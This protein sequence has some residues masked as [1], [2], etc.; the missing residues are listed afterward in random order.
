[1]F[2][3]VTSSHTAPRRRL[4]LLMTCWS[5]PGVCPLSPALLPAQ[6]PPRPLMVLH[7]PRPPPSRTTTT[8]PSS[9][10]PPPAL[11]SHTTCPSP[12]PSR[13]MRCALW[14]RHQH[15]PSLSSTSQL[16]TTTAASFPLLME[17]ARKAGM[18]WRNPSTLALTV[19]NIMQQVATW[20]DTGKLIAVS[21]PPT[22][23]NV[24]FVTRCMWVCL[25]SACTFSL[26]TS[27]TNVNS[28]ERHS[29]DLGCYKDIWD[30][31]RETNHTP[32]MSARS[33]LQT[34]LTWEHTC[35]H[36]QQQRTSTVLDATNPLH[37]SPIWTNI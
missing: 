32:V 22:P 3:T 2:P 31:I 18:S 25:L 15:N 16:Q 30:L 26:T 11:L 13:T 10:S 20:A 37:W 4:R 19:A 23:R 36:I 27:T 34:D 33:P 1:M 14:S 29:Q 6:L 35:K 9:T 21:T 8:P 17:G 24:T 5:C 7:P 28:V 12:H